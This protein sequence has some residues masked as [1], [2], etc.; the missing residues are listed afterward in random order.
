MRKHYLD[1]MRWIIILTV[2]P[3]HILF[4]SNSY[5]LGSSM[6]GMKNYPIMD[7]I[8]VTLYSRWIMPLLCMISG[9]V[10]RYSL[11]S[12]TNKQFLKNRVDRLLVP[13]TL[14]LF[15]YQWLTSLIVTYANDPETLYTNT[16]AIAT[17]VKYIIFAVLGTGPLWV[18]QILFVC[19]CALLIIRKIDKNDKIYKLCGKMN[20]PVLIAMFA[21]VAIFAFCLN[22]KSDYR[23]LYIYKLGTCMAVFLLG[24]YALSQDKIQKLLEKRY[25]LLSCIAIASTIFLA[26]Y[27]VYV[28]KNTERYVSYIKHGDSILVIW[29]IWIVMLAVFS[30]AGRY[31][32]KEN[33]FTRYMSKI[34]YGILIVHYPILLFFCL[35]IAPL[36]LPIFVNHLLITVLTFAFSFVVYQIL[37]RIP[38]VRYCVFGFRKESK[39]IE[40]K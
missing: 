40:K 32:N 14:G 3:F 20:L 30:F 7:M 38:V 23:A 31:L 27:N 2:I 10:A 1:N 24:Y 5:G 17:V 11:N 29:Y 39:N 33:A 19:C 37:R 21:V 25:I 12:R 9:V 36:G 4:T 6:P 15:V 18:A 26:V 13:G 16:G 8:S 28:S 35:I 22:V 34:S